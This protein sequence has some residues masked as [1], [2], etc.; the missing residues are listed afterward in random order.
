M[1]TWFTSD[2][3]FFHRNVIE[4]CNRPYRDANGEPDVPHMNEDI[5]K[6]HNE[7]VQPDDT[8]YC[9]GDF[10]FAV[11]PVELYSERLNGKKKLVPG[12]HDPC[13]PCNKHSRT[14]E[15]QANM[16]AK[17]E[18]HGWEVLPIHSQLNLEGCALV[19]LCHLPYKGDSTDERHQRHRMDDDGR[20]LICG[21][22]HQHWKTKFTPKGTLMVNVGVDVWDMKPVSEEKLKELILN[23][24]RD[25]S[26]GII[27]P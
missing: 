19:N 6:L 20:V 24:L 7:L 2:P 10:S 5:I 8:V 18:A 21:H 27:A 4:Y 23:T 15:R 25:K 9:L 14:P 17:Y 26:A 3:H 22:V 12:N 1:T 16:I 13:H 11:R